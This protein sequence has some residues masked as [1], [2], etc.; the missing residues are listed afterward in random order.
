MELTFLSIFQKICTQRM[1]QNENEIR[2]PF[3]IETIKLF[4]IFLFV[5]FVEHINLKKDSLHYYRFKITKFT[6]FRFSLFGFVLKIILIDAVKRMSV[7]VPAGR[8]KP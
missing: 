6:H 3:I 4:C 8:S 1:R 7:R 2:E 5:Y